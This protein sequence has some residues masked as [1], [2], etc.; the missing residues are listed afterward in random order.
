MAPWG[1]RAQ[2]DVPAVGRELYGDALTRVVH[3]RDERCVVFVGP[4]GL[5]EDQDDGLVHTQKVRVATGS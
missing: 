5:V 1:L 4:D 3:Y 2:R